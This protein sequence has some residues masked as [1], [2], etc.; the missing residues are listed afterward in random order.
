MRAIPSPSPGRRRLQTDPAIDPTT[1]RL[2]ANA[3]AGERTY[4]L[5]EDALTWE[6][7]GKPLDGV[8]YDDIAEVRLTF[9]PTRVVTNRYRTQIIFRQG[10][11]IDLTNADYVSLAN[12]VEKNAEYAAFLRELHR[13]LAARGRDTVFRK[14]SSTAGYIAGLFLTVF[15]LAMIALAFLLL[16]NF[17]IVWI[18]VIKLVIILYFVPTL[19][20]FIRRARPAG[21]DPLDLP[22]DVLPG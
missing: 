17:G 9:A 16:F 21:Y 19:I 20:R 5:T 22:A 2:R 1:F 4:R 11:S 8:F 14:G 10:G 12:F 6:E 18:A 7:E 15:I 13:R 3:F